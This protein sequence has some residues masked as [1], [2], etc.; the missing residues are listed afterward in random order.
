MCE[1]SAQTDMVTF[2]WLKNN[3]EISLS[4]SVRIK[5]DQEFSVLIIDPVSLEDEG[6]YT[7]IASNAEGSAKYTAYL[8]VKGKNH[9][10]IYPDIKYN[11]CLSTAK[12]WQWSE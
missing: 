9:F 6:N 5:H 4:K 2:R 3:K 10:S 7:C 12:L 8:S 11:L 1:V